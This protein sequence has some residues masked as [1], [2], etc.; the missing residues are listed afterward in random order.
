M[1]SLISDQKLSRSSNRA[2][3]SMVIS[4]ALSAVFQLSREAVL[5][6]PVCRSRGTVTTA[7][8]RLSGARLP[9][10]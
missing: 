9:R 5:K 3:V 10:K 4:L 6:S 7:R 2:M 8:P 1:S